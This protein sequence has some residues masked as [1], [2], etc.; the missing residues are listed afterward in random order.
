M[1]R[2]S[3]SWSAATDRDHGTFEQV[4]KVTGSDESASQKTYVH[5]SFVMTTSFE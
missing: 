2:T 4:A 1:R 3:D 5:C